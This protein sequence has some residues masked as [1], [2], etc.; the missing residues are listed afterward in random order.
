MNLNRICLGVVAA[1]TLAAGPFPSGVTRGTAPLHVNGNTVYSDASTTSAP[2]YMTTNQAIALASLVAALPTPVPAAST[3]PP[4]TFPNGIVV[5]EVGASTVLAADTFTGANT[6][7]INGRSTTSG[8]KTWVTPYGTLQTGTWGITSN[9]ATTSLASGGTNAVIDTGAVSGQA[10]VTVTSKGTGVTN[11]GIEFRCSASGDCLWF[12]W[13]NGACYGIGYS[14]GAGVG[15]GTVYTNDGCVNSLT[16][17]DILS[18]SYDGN[19][20]N[21]YRNGVLYLTTTQSQN[22][23]ETRAGISTGGGSVSVQFDDFSVQTIAVP[24]AL[25]IDVPLGGGGVQVPSQMVLGSSLS[26]AGTSTLT[27][28]VTANGGITGGGSNTFNVNATNVETVSQSFFLTDHAR[29][30]CNAGNAGRLA[31]DSGTFYGCD[32]ATWN[33]L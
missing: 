14:T 17:G 33:A 9:R 22:N 32:G 19:V 6:S 31:Y 21:G 5:R 1:L 8:A 11:E 15:N 2:G 23:T 30:L 24:V 20:I 29:G 18:V 7:N 3:F 10:Y 4:L 28:A 13:Y 27:G 25:V 26:V 12:G 16:N